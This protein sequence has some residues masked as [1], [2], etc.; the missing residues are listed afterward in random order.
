MINWRSLCWDIERQICFG[1][2]HFIFIRIANCVWFHF[3]CSFASFSI[4]IRF[5]LFLAKIL[6]D[7]IYKN[8][9]TIQNGASI[10]RLFQIIV[11]RHRIH[12]SVVHSIFQ[13]FSIDLCLYIHW[14]TMMLWYTRKARPFRMKWQR[15]EEKTNYIYNNGKTH[16]KRI[17]RK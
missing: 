13:Q 10:H 1:C 3:C 6:E 7:S 4:S 17:D 8:S 14:W 5:F 12:I 15:N 11:W 9:P 16:R 2:F